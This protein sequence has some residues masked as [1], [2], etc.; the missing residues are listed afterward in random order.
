MDRFQ[1]LPPATAADLGPGLFAGMRAFQLDDP[2]RIERMLGTP[3][4]PPEEPSLGG[5]LR[6]RA[7]L[8][9]STL[10]HDI[11]A[12]PGRSTTDL[13]IS[14]DDWLAKER[15]AA[16]ANALAVLPKPETTGAATQLAFGLATQ[17]PELIVG[18]ATGGPPGAFAYE[19]MVESALARTRLEAAGVRPEDATKLGLI[20]GAA[21]G[22]VAF[23]PPVF[24]QGAK[25][26]LG[27][28]GYQAVGQGTVNTLI[29]TSTR[30][31]S[32]A[33]LSSHGYAAL[34]EQYRPFAGSEMALDFLLGAGLGVF[35]VKGWQKPLV[36]RGLSTVDALLHVNSAA[37]ADLDV[38]PGIPSDI[39]AANAN[40]DAIAAETERLITGEGPR[41]DIPAIV[42]GAKFLP[43]A[44]AVAKQLDVLFEE[45]QGTLAQLAA[46]HER[47][48]F[49]DLKLPEPKAPALD[50][51][52]IRGEIGWAEVGGRI[53]REQAPIED[54]AMGSLGAQGEVVGRT[55]WIPRSDFWPNRPDKS[56]SERGAHA[57]LD[58]LASGERLTPKEQRF[59][60]YARETLHGRES[61]AMTAELEARAEREAIQREGVTDADLAHAGFGELNADQQLVV[62]RHLDYVAFHD[63]QRAEIERALESDRE[64]ASRGPQGVQP[65]RTEAG[66]RRAAKGQPAPAQ[67]RGQEQVAEPG[68]L[69]RYTSDELRQR[70]QNAIAAATADAAKRKAAEDRAVADAQRDAFGLVGSDRPA[71][72]NPNQSS[73][74][75]PTAPHRG[76]AEAQPY[77]GTLDNPTSRDTAIAAADARVAEAESNADA[78]VKAAVDCGRVEGSP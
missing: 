18:F 53:I 49:A 10:A 74:L 52:P 29:G 75:E 60:T 4:L 48:Q 71:D 2:Y 20:Q 62:Q 61:E 57:A 51:G 78:A 56:L 1:T 40:A 23:I 55:K 9:V 27:R 26:L 24:G 34:A 33:Y 59:I 28:I 16:R 54:V 73:L 45:A 22:S 5:A 65:A 70:E 19:T 50:L 58:K 15:D 21:A 8:G 42:D 63:E 67:A 72:A 17:L 68:L 39:R 66:A 32:T 6:A 12:T 64:A 41:P 47:V 31:A 7:R 36:D 35:Q 43:P 3:G 77:P 13:G 11:I 76:A 38:A 37:H 46:E 30:A 69:A 44:P 14:L 25:T